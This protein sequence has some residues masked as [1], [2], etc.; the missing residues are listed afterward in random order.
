MIPVISVVGKSDSG[1]TTL[2]EKLIVELKQRGYRVATVK[3][4]IHSFEIDVPGKDSWRHAQAG[5]DIVVISSPRKLALIKRVVQ[6]MTLEEIA[7][8]IPEVDTEVDIILTEGFKRAKAPKVE[9]SRRDRSTELICE[10]DELIAVATD[11]PLSID[12]PT[13][14][15]ED[16]SGLADLLEAAFLRHPS[17]PRVSLV[18]D[19][20]RV[21][22]WKPFV[23]AVLEKTVRGMLSALQGVKAGGR[24]VLTIE[25]KAENQ[26]LALTSTQAWSEGTERASS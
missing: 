22:I 12:V 8:L 25:A 20:E 14:D 6:E 13:F 15:L 23:A 7:R 3:H 10:P 2:L 16:I 26:A 21:P 18:V 17:R 4:D 1:K 24:V 19:G 9:V 5:S 11:Y